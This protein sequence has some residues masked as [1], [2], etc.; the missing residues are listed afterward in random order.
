MKLFR[1]KR[2][3]ESGQEEKELVLD[4]NAEAQAPAQDTT[5]A[6]VETAAP[7][8][9]PTPDA[10]AEVETPVQEEAP[11][12][13]GDLMSQISAEADS[14]IDAE[15]KASE[16]D[17]PLDPDLADIFR[18]A[19][20]EV[21]ESSLAAEL[22]DIAAQELLSDLVNISESLSKTLRVRPEASKDGK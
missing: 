17:D 9:H 11:A 20:N 2:K 21:E 5:E 6:A 19:K 7:A 13:E 12:P 1:L 16:E 15:E 10:E 18:E 22:E 8:D 3:P 14:E 4:T